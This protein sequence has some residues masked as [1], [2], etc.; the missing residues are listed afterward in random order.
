MQ[1]M[2]ITRA[3]A[4]FSEIISRLIHRKEAVVITRK[5]RPV[6]AI[7]PYEEW[8]RRTAAKPEGLAAAAGALAEFDEEIGTILEAVYAARLEDEDREVSI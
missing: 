1:I 6:A 8:A 5:R 7:V 3:K 2:T 4:R